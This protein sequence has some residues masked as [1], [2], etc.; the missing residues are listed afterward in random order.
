MSEH[1]GWCGDAPCT[2]PDATWEH[3]P[4][5]DGDTQWM[6]PGEAGGDEGSTW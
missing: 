6:D 3:D 5:D 4:D 1:C 2:C